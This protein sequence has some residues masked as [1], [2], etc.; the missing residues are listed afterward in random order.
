MYT[1]HTMSVWSVSM[2]SSLCAEKS[3]HLYSRPYIRWDNGKVGDSLSMMQ[4]ALYKTGITKAA[5]KDLLLKTK[6]TRY[7]LFHIHHLQGQ[8][9]GNVWRNP[10][11]ILTQK[12]L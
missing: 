8:T 6:A 1:Y 5:R 3:L 7:L 10:S 9:K 4:K 11:F 2:V 12:Q